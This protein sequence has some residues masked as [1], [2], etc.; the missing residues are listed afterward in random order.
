ML[1][2]F[3][4]FWVTRTALPYIL[5]ETGHVVSQ[6]NTDEN[7]YNILPSSKYLFS[8]LALSGLQSPLWLAP[9]GNIPSFKEYKDAASLSKTLI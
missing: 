8:L 7:P 5:I 6:G 1:T 4:S 9:L 2:I 3:E